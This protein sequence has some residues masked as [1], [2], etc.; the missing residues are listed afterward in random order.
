VAVAA[1]VVDIAG[2]E[3]SQLWTCYKSNCTSRT[4][5]HQGSINSIDFYAI[6]VFVTFSR[7]Y[8]NHRPRQQLLFPQP[9]TLIIHV[10]AHQ[11]PTA[12]V[13]YSRRLVEEPDSLSKKK[14]SGLA[15]TVDPPCTRVHLHSNNARKNSLHIRGCA[16]WIRFNAII[17]IIIWG[18]LPGFELIRFGFRVDLPFGFESVRFG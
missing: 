13:Q 2:F 12:Q 16:V 17:I 6:Y 11:S 8:L 18:S 5:F 4:G 1:S 14:G 7:D 3:I 10:H 15:V 9:S